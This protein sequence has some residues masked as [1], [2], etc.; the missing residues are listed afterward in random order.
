MMGKDIE[1]LITYL[2]KTKDLVY[3]IDSDI[4]TLNNTVQDI[5]TNAQTTIQL[6]WMN[7]MIPL[8]T[9]AKPYIDKVMGMETKM[10]GKSSEF[11][12]SIGSP[13]N[14][15]RKFNELY[16]RINSIIAPTYKGGRSGLMALLS[17]LYASIVDCKWALTYYNDYIQR[18]Y[19]N[20]YNGNI[21]SITVNRNK[22]KKTTGN[23]D[24][25]VD[26]NVSVPKKSITP[27]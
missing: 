26:N 2:E 24:Q 15:F 13:W 12:N 23:V 7:K 16:T 25:E 5:D 19:D 9:E 18:G 27:Y 20:L 4:Y 17:M 10:F 22:G 8:I 1:T 6:T 11:N 21:P 3:S 14:E